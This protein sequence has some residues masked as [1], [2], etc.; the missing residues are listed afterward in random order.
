MSGVREADLFLLAVRFLLH[1]ADHAAP[2]PVSGRLEMR[3]ASSLPLT[4]RVDL[5]TRAVFVGY[6]TGVEALTFDDSRSNTEVS[7]VCPNIDACHSIGMQRACKLQQ[8]HPFGV[9]YRLTQGL[10]PSG[11]PGSCRGDQTD[12]GVPW[13]GAENES[14]D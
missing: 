13:D 3:A 8:S 14:V 10:C 6:V 1:R 4:F 12:S 9:V 5:S 2:S 7:L 11:M